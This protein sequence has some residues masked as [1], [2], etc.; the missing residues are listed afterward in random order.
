MN[1]NHTQS[2][3]NNILDYL[4]ANH[5]EKRQPSRHTS[6]HWQLFGSSQHIEKVDNEYKLRGIGFGEYKEASITNSLL[7]APTR[8]Y[9]AIL[10]Q[11]L[12]LKYREALTKLALSTNRILCHDMVRMALTIQLLASHLPN[13]E[14]KKIAIIG[15]G[16]GTM[17]SLLK[18]LFPNCQVTYINL[19]R[20]LAFDVLY[21][22]RAHPDAH[23]TLI[24]NGSEPTSDGFN[25]VEAEK[26]FE[27]G[28]QADLFINIVSMQEMNPSIILEYV[29][30]M[31]SQ[32]NE[33]WF[34]CCNRLEKRLP[35][36][37]ITRFSEYGWQ[38]EDSFSVDELCPWHQLAP[39]NRPPFFRK[40]DGPIHHRLARL[41]RAC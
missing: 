11:R 5:Y 28:A 29:Q 17:G 15:D 18:M 31:R 24:T 4:L 25:Y 35:D 6:A 37:T 33:V 1:L 3:T 9:L 41:H 19:G 22:A 27:I 38:G 36:G 10:L 39:M 40:F 23:H 7:T 13:L 2:S 16:Y 14:G 30:L 32:P 12:N 8:L 20:T 21:T 34:Y 26:V